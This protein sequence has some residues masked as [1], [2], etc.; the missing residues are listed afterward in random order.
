M[1]ARIILIPFLCIWCA[2]TP[3][4]AAARQVCTTI[5]IYTATGCPHCGRALDFL[6]QLSAD[7]PQVT[8]HNYD[9]RTDTRAMERFIAINQKVGEAHPGVPTFLICGQ[10]FIGFDDAATTGAAIKRLMGLQPVAK[11]PSDTTFNLPVFGTL[12]LSTVGMPLF[13]LVLGLVDGFNPCAMWVLLILLS[14]LVNLRDR[15]RLAL[16]AGT[17]VFISGAVYFAFMAA[18]LNLFLIMGASRLIQIVIGLFAVAVGA[19]HIKDYFAFKNGISLSIPDSARPGLYQRMR[20]VVYAE[21][22]FA[23]LVTVSVLAMLVNLV[24]LACTAGIPALYTQIL[25][26]R[27]PDSLHYY[28]YLLLYNLAYIFDDTV[29]VTIAVFTLSSRKLQESE[30]RWLKLISGGVICAVGTVLIAAPQ[31][32]I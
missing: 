23:A 7:Y 16:I 26:N 25:A 19:I 27:E 30:G 24:E 5:E 32:L 31:W 20:S 4:T 8:V 14:L 18:W 3:V 6:R 13:T 9:I 11:P 29:M 12:S 21:N 28:G 2:V 10:F 15:R 1:P 22:L 17:F